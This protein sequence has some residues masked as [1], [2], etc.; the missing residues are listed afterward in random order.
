[1]K[2]IICRCCFHLTH[3]FEVSRFEV[4]ISRFFWAFF[5]NLQICMWWG[6]EGLRVSLHKFEKEPN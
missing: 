4:L 5:Q 2:Q 3:I 1:M 6:L